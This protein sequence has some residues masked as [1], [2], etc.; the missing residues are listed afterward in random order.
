M[1]PVQMMIYNEPFFFYTTERKI[2]TQSFRFGRN[3]MTDTRVH[4]QG[5]Y[6]Q[7]KH[8]CFEEIFQIYI[9]FLSC[10]T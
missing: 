9:F 5:N 10:D 8:F 6:L 1:F 7:M 3:N 4:L 2:K